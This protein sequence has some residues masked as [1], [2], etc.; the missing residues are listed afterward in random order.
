MVIIVDLS[1]YSESIIGNDVLEIIKEGGSR[2]RSKALNFQKVVE[3]RRR[4]C[5]SSLKTVSGRKLR[6]EDPENGFPLR[7]M[8]VIGTL[9]L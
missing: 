2:G 4:K 7:V 1:T 9:R 6:C 8:R 3:S 5:I